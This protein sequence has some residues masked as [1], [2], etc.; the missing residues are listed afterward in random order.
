M[1][2]V[3]DCI[4]RTRCGS[5]SVGPETAVRGKRLQASLVAWAIS[6]RG[7]CGCGVWRERGIASGQASG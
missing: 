5:G 7:L 2:W 3:Q 1:I 6:F 4:E